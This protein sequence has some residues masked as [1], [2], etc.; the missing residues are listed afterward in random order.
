MID[1]DSEMTNVDRLVAFLPYVWAD[2]WCL[3]RLNERP[4]SNPYGQN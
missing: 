3:K 1:R 2:E 4:A